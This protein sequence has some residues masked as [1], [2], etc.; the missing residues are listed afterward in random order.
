MKNKNEKLINNS[1]DSE[2]LEQNSE[3]VKDVQNEKKNNQ[4]VKANN[5]AAKG[6]AKAKN[7]NG[8]VRFFKRIGRAFKGMVEELKKVNWPSFATT[9][10]STGVVLAFVV[11]FLAVLM[12]MDALF[13]LGFSS[14][15]GIQG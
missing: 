8:F 12:A 6:K 2:A 13:G 5:K 4:P 7:E 1:L 11:V 9:M 15:I 14:L 10:K 3:I